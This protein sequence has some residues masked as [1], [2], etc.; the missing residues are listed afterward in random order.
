MAVHLAPLH[1]QVNRRGSRITAHHLKLRS[2]HFVEHERKINTVRA[3]RGPTHFERF[4]GS[5]NL[6]E[7]FNSRKSHD[8]ADGN[9]FARSS[10]PAKLSRIEVNVRIAQRL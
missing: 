5:E 2:K 1:G 8:R 3:G 10:D 6:I 7:C 9:S 4:V